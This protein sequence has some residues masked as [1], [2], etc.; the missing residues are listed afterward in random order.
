MSAF[1]CRHLVAILGIWAI[2]GHAGGEPLK[3]TILPIAPSFEEDRSDASPRYIWRIPGTAVML[4]NGGSIAVIESAGVQAHITFVG[5]NARSEPRGELQSGSKAIY[6]VGPAEAWRTGSHFDRIRYP[7]IYPGIDLVFVTT[8]DRLEYNFEISPF[9]DPG[10][11][12]IHYAGAYLHLTY[13]GDLQMHA[14]MG[15]ITQRRPMAFQNVPG[16]QPHV[17]CEYRLKNH[18]EAVLRVGLYDR[19][20]P[21]FIDPVLDFST[22]LGGSSFDSIYASAVDVHGNLYVTGE[23][24]SG[25]LTVPSLAPRSS[26]DA[27][28]AKLNSAGSQ[29]TVAYLGGSSYDSGRGIALDPTGNIYVTGVTDSSDFP[30][31]QGALATHLPGAQDAFVAKFNNAFVLQYSTY[32]GGGSADAGLAIAVDSTGAAYVA[33]QTQST[34]FPVS[35]GAF[36]KSNGGGISDCFVSKLNPAGSA[37]DYSTFLGGSA[38]DIC[39]GI[40][41]DTSENAYVTG[42]TYSTNFPSVDALQNSLGGTASAFATKVNATGSAL[43]YSTYLGG[44]N[45]DNASAIA[46]DS[47]GAA[48]L[49]GDTASID[50]PTTPGVFQSQLNGSYNAFVSKLSPAGSA[51]VYSTFVGGSGSDVGTSIAIDSTGRAIVGGYTSSSNFPTSGA[52]QSAFQGIFD[53]FSTVLDP[54]GATLVFSSYLGGSNDDRGYTVA[55]GPSNNLFL[56]GMTSSSNFPVAAAIQPTL[57][58]PPD[59][60]VSEITYVSGTPMVVAVTPSSGSGLSQTFALQYSD[61]AGAASLQKVWVWFGSSLMSSVNACVLNYNVSTNQVTL[62][63]NNGATALTATVG[64]ATT[65]LNSQCSLNVAATSVALS[66]GNLTLNLAMTFA[67]AYAGPKNIYMW[68]GDVSGSNTGWIEEGT[69]TV[70][71]SGTPAVVSVTPSAGSGMSQTFALKYS[72]TAG[73]TSLQKVWVWLGASLT[74]SVNSCILNYNA[75]SNQVTLLANDG[76]TPLTAT[77][78]AATTLQNSQCSLNVGSTSVVL[79]GSNLTLNLA[80]TFEAAYAGARN[81]YL[82]AADVSGSNTGWEQLGT[83]TAV[84]SGPGIPATVSVMPSSGSGLSQ[85]FVLEYSDPAGAASLQKVWVWLGASLASSVNSCVL[86]YNVPSN[87]V[88]LLANDGGTPLTA[89][90]GAATTLENSQCSLNVASSSVALSGNN[91]TLNLALTFQAAYAG[92]QNIF[93]YAADASGS[94]SGWQQRGTWTVP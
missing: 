5:A 25:S 91:L 53:A 37:L 40:A 44:S 23:T 86:N 59:A 56:A 41:I 85:N 71:A 76:G 19:A 35:S 51:L 94:N 78:G 1:L 57:S 4:K 54:V 31:T 73:A 11:I 88:T 17:T 32:L 70:T 7:G 83:W 64:A 46:V 82:Y 81:I 50:F 6:Y 36:Q 20:N 43:I 13:G 92:D 68:A 8:G 28:I 3:R 55:V 61:T 10:V 42:T 24:G 66:G 12:R 72:D 49:T 29:I 18:H 34:G 47:S 90:V 21:L 14:G 16:Q 58:T 52:I 80:M 69:W 60:F 93:M 67:A 9:A 63:A 39:T 30:V 33:G 65:L 84:V 77:V 27:F 74:S 48:Y 45:V 38:L 79:S 2:V 26:R 87:Q 62:L 89:T 22:Y 75:A 15:T